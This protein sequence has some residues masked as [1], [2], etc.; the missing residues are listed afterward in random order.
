MNMVSHKNRRGFTVIEVILGIVVATL[1]GAAV[2]S[3]A[4]TIISNSSLF[5]TSIS[6]K[7]SIRKVFK[8]FSSE[9][10]SS[11]Y[12]WNGTYVI[13]IASSTSFAFYTNIDADKYTERVNYYLDGDKIIKQTNKYNIVTNRYDTGTT[14]KVVLNN[15]IYSSTTPM[16]K[17]YDSGFDGTDSYGSLSDPVDISKIRLVDFSVVTSNLGKKYNTQEFDEIKVTLRNLKDNY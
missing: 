17:Y 3:F 9:V 16:F 5:Q 8:D 6:T 14:T 11:Y 7:S 10:R 1:V 2:I 15:Y 12:A 13:E 4:R